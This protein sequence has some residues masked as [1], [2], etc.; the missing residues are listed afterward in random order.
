MCDCMEIVWIGYNCPLY[1]ELYGFS[2]VHV[3]FIMHVVRYY[4]QWRIALH[5][6]GN[7]TLNGCECMVENQNCV[8]CLIV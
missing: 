4:M 5:M 8:W 3:A 6:H 2:I 7:I 1:T